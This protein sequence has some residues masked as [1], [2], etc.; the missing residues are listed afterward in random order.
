MT[1]LADAQAQLAAWEAA[2]LALAKSQ[3]YTISVEGS[4]R[5]LTRADG[6]EVREM[7][8]YWTR[9][10]AELAAGGRRPRSRRVVFG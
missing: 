5:T 2:S 4:Q 1:T 9:R 6:A 8:A 3:S 10:V 7:I